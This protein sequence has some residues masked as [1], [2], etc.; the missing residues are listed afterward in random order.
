MPYG[1]ITA[2]IRGISFLFL[3]VTILII[4][5]IIMITNHQTS[6]QVPLSLYSSFSR[7]LTFRPQ[8]LYS[9]IFR[10]F[11][12]LL[13]AYKKVTKQ[14]KCTPAV[15][16]MYFCMTKISSSFLNVVRYFEFKC[17]IRLY[18]ARSKLKNHKTVNKSGFF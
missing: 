14:S 5:Y 15:V 17:L 8:L 2:T 6:N 18:E 1:L 9:C 13:T 7:L 16:N 11:F 3:I 10:K 12:E 4:K